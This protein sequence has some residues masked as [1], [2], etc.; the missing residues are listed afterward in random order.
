M[1]P[2][3]VNESLTNWLAETFGNG[4]IIKRT[5][6]VGGGSINEAHRIS[7]SCGDFFLKYNLAG[8]YPQM[9]ELEMKGLKLLASTNTIYIP[10]ALYAGF[11]D[12]YSF[13]ILEY[14]EKA[15]PRE[16]FWT[17]FASQLARL[18]QQTDDYY[19]LG[20]DNYI[21]SLK[22]SNL[23]TT[24]YLS[25][26]INQRIIPLVK[27]ALDSKLLSHDDLVQFQK[28]F[29]RL[30]DLLTIEKPALIHGDLWSGNIIVN[31][32]GMPCLIDPAIYYGHR[33][34][35]IAMTR[36]FGGFPNLFYEA[37]ND[38]F[39]MS[40]GW[41]ERIEIHQLYPL[42]VHVNLFGQSYVPQVRRIIR[43]FC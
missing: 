8:L 28:L 36:L 29:L 27:S 20:Y 2:S 24:D 22:Q 23:I 43:R 30:G 16:N 3:E 21:G 15:E 11:T 18:H 13:L 39:P 42:L 25:F 31:H 6:P 9:F 33:E 19:G 34:S 40:K 26:F 14:E 12:K 37:Y 10:E 38:E 4:C 7:T 32:N 5:T 1:L 41:V 35:D 17:L